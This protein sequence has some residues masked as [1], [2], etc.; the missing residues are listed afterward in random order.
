MRERMRWLPTTVVT[1]VD[2]ARAH[3]WRPSP[4]PK[5]SGV[6]RRTTAPRRV[7]VAG[8]CPFGHTQR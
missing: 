3:G 1:L 7:E 8:C 6:L 2:G 4:L 5:R